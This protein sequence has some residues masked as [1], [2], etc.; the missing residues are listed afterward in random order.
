MTEQTVPAKILVVD[1]EPGMRK[2]LHNYLTR[3]GYEVTVAAS[4][5]EALEKLGQEHFELVV[6]DLVMQGGDGYVVMEYIERE[7]PCTAVIVITA[8]GSTDSAVEALRRGAVDYVQKPFEIDLMAL[9]VKRALEQK[10]LSRQVAYRARQLAV[11]AE[12]TQ[13]INAELDIQEVY[14]TLAHEAGRVVELDTMTLSLL[15]PDGQQL[16]QR[17]LLGPNSSVAGEPS[18]VSVE[19]SLEGWCLEQGNSIFSSDIARDDLLPERTLSLPSSIHSVLIVPLVVKSKPI[20]VLSLGH[21]QPHAY[22]Q[23][24]LLIV[25]QMAGQLATAIEN[26]RLLQQTQEQLE[27]LQ[28]AQTRLISSARLAAVGELARGLAHELN[29]PLSV[30]MGLVQFLQLQPDIPEQTAADLQ[31]ISKSA[32]RMARLIRNFAEFAR[33][34]L[35]EESHFIDVNLIVEQALELV[36]ASLIKHNIRVETSLASPPPIIFGYSH[37][38]KQMLLNLLFNAHEAIARVEPPVKGHEISVETFISQEGENGIWVHIAVCDTGGGIDPIHLPC[39]FDPGYTTK[40]ENGT[41]RGLGMGLYVSY[42]LAQAHGGTIRVK[43]E[44]GQGS[45]FTIRL[46]VEKKA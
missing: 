31:K 7:C 10:R 6:T 36:R 29:N 1:D 30:I 35:E 19:N 20:G 5:D 43:S 28:R 18:V 27:T 25:E 4:G 41:I 16:E 34:A 22:S 37:Q 15:A 44:P 14:K 17:A 42:G 33:P 46:P 21:N 39:I 24:D 23:D 26:A 12:I 2:I 45:C 40:V 32:L 38:I 13:A 9:T 8:Y 3:E 11:L